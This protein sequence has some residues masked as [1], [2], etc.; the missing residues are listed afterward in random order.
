MISIVFR[1]NICFLENVCRGSLGRFR[2]HAISGVAIQVRRA[3]FGAS[4]KSLLCLTDES[5][6]RGANDNTRGR[7]RS[8][9]KSIAART[10]L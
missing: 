6:W 7:V 1:R 4:P 5:R 9:E 10:A 3:D 8:P 2:C